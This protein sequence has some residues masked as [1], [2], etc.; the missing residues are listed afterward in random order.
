MA[1]QT[2]PA[3]PTPAPLVWVF[4]QK[5]T[6]PQGWVRGVTYAET[7][8]AAWRALGVMV[9]PD[10]A[11]TMMLER[12]VRLARVVD[13]QQAIAYLTVVAEDR[14]CRHRLKGAERLAA[15]YEDQAAAVSA[16]LSL[17]HLDD[18][19]ILCRVRTVA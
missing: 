18:M 15:V 5:C 13:R 19:D 9:G 14:P 1:A 2:G 16:D 17:H 8:R 11:K 7:E 12:Q 4:L 6:C 10:T 3:K